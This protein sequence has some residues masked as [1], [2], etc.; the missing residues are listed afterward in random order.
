MSPAFIFTAA[1]L[2]GIIIGLLTPM[3][4]AY[5]RPVRI[6]VYRKTPAKYTEELHVGSIHVK[7]VDADD[8]PFDLPEWLNANPEPVKDW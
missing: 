2:C 3:V 7:H 1:L 6:T 5:I 4:V 8:D